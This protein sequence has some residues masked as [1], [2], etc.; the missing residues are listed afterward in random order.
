MRFSPAVWSCL[1]KTAGETHRN[2]LESSCENSIF[3]WTVTKWWSTGEYI[4]ESQI[5]FSKNKIAAL[6][7]LSS[8]VINSGVKVIIEQIKGD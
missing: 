1:V 2:V 5:Y 6:S 4:K 3:G 8:P 7:S